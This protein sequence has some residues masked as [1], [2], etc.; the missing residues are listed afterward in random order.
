MRKRIIPHDPPSVAPTDA[1]WLDLD[2]LAQVELSSEDPAHPIEGALHPG[3]D[4]RWQAAQAGEQTIRLVFNQPQRVRQIHLA[5]DEP[6]HART[7]EVVLHWSADG[8]RSYQALL[9][10]QYTFS[11]PGTTREVE[12]VTVN[13][14]GVT[15]L[16]V[17]II[18]DIS[19][20]DVRATLAELHLA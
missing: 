15:G 8:G 12:D 16:E 4:A 7:Q 19:G 17:R 18:P 1:P 14:E 10:Q 6:T 5:V 11:P 3:S 9:R 20:G 2:Q 13:L